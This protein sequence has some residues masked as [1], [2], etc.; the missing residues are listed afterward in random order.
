MMK[1]LKKSRIT[2]KLDKN[3]KE[4][5]LFRSPYV[6]LFITGIIFLLFG[7]VLFFPLGKL[8]EPNIILNNLDFISDFK[9]LKEALLRNPFF[10]KGGEF[11]RPVQNLSFMVDAHLSGA[12]GWAYYL[13]NILLHA[14]TAS[15]LYYLLNLFGNSRKVSLMLT[16]FF[17][18]HPLFVQTVAWAPSRG[19][20]L[21]STFGL[22]SFIAFA[23]YIRKGKYLYLLIH[24]TSFGLALFSKETG[25]LIPVLCGLYYFFIEKETKIRTKKLILPLF[26]YGIVVACFF[27]SRTQFANIDAHNEQVGW[28]PLLHNLPAIPELL[29]KFILPLNLNPMPV[30]NWL[31]TIGGIVALTAIIFLSIK[32]HSG[33]D[34]LFLYGLAWFLLVLF[35]TLIYSHKYGSAA[36]DY[37]E[38]RAYFPA[39]GIVLFISRIFYTDKLHVKSGNIAGYFPLLIIVYG[40]YAFIYTRNYRD[41]EQFYNRVIS[42]NPE[43]AVG[44]FCHGTVIMNMKKNYT[45]AIQDFDKSIS[46][47][48]DYPQALLNRGYCH[49]QIQDFNGAL[50][51]YRAASHIAPLSYDPH[52]NIAAIYT[53]QGLINDAL[54]EYDTALLL[55]PS[56]IDGYNERGRLYA[57]NQDYS[58]AADDFGKAISLNPRNDQSFVERGIVRFQMGD[59]PSASE[60]FNQALLINPKNYTAYLK[61][62]ILKFQQQDFD[63]AVSDM[64]QAI[65]LNDRYE[66]AYLN[67]GKVKYFKGDLD[68]ACQDWNSSNQLGNQ[69]AGTL[70]Q[71]YCNGKTE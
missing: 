55:N 23:Q 61:R 51:D 4:F 53:S 33:N 10:H 13:S 56:F 8:D 6:Y 68:G 22:I 40:V 19:D 3:K 5:I 50:E 11:Y 25:V 18:I 37:L 39:I 59:Y 21:M 29:F 34:R 15:L 43:S 41:P 24:L 35:P 62:G 1:D 38:H 42:L 20:L 46:I 36:Y 9:N 2:A 52:V 31:P 48:P 64:D 67:R 70:L 54:R 47:K 69:E 57:I 17:A 30:F 45:G 71:R 12:N 26:C 66:E 16:L 58:R 27:Y 44:Y 7:Q 60:D 32:Y 65:N 49:E 63:A 14:T 28:G